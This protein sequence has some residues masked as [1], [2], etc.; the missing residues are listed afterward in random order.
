MIKLTFVL[1]ITALLQISSA[2]SFS[3]TV[4]LKFRNAKLETVLKEI[5]TQTGYDLVYI[6]PLINEAK[7]VSIN[8][9]NASLRE[10]LE[11]SFSNQSLTYT[12][13]NN[14]II[15]QQK[16]T[17]LVTS[18]LID[19]KKLSEKAPPTEVKGQVTDSKGESLIG[20]SVIV[21]GTSIGVSTDV[22]GRYTINVPDGSSVL[23]FTYIGYTTIEVS[24]SGRTSLDVTLE[25][26]TE[27]LQEVVVVGYG[28]QKKSDLTGSVVSVTAKD[29]KDQSFSNINQVLQGKVAGV[30]FTSTSGDPGENVNV[31][32]RGLNTFGGSGPLYVVDGMPMEASD[33]NSINPNDVQSTTVLKDGSAA[34]IYG[35]RSANGVILIT[36]KSGGDRPPSIS[37]NSYYGIQ[38]FNKF[39]PLLN[40]QQYADVINEAH[41]NGNFYPLQAAMN[42]P[43]NL[44]TNTD[45]QDAAIN[46]APIQDHSLTVSGGTKNA[47]YSISGGIFDQESVLAFRTYKR[48][49]SRVKTEFKIGKLTIGQSLIATKE[50]GLNLN[51]GNNLDLAYMMG[52]APTMPI[53]DPNNN[54]GYAG[55]SPAT[56]GVNNRDNILGRRDMNRAY[57]TNNKLIG[58]AYASYKIL[59]D[60]EYKLNTG[61][62]MGLRRFKNYVPQFQMNNR[63]SNARRLNTSLRESYEYL[64]EN[65]L[66]YNK[67]IKENYRISLLG[68]F[69]QQNFFGNSINGTR[70]DF[71]SN[72]IQVLSAGTGVYTVGG[73]E[74]EWALRSFLGR[75][76]ITLFDRYLITAT[77]RRDG[78]SRFGESNR[79][80]NF[81]SL[82]VG[83]NLDQE[84][85]LKDSK[86]ISGMKLRASWGRLGNQDI[87]NY[88]NQTVVSTNSRYFFGADQLAPAAVVNNLGNPFLRWETTTQ[89]NLGVDLSFLQNKIFFTADYWIKDTDGILVRTPISTVTG[90]ARGSGPFQNA[91]QLQNKGMEF[92]LGY[93]GGTGELKYGVSG[94][95]STVRNKVISL[96]AGSSIINLVENVY[97]SGTYT[98]TMPGLPM[99]HFYGH[100]ND[101]IFQTQAEINAHAT[102]AGAK[103]GDRRFRDINGDGKVDA[104][105]RT[106]IGDPWPDFDY[107]FAADASWKG[108]DVNMSFY[109]TSGKQLYDS[110]GVYLETMQGEWNNKT[111]VLNRWTGPG[112]S[113]TLPR[114]VRGDRNQNNRSQSDYVLN[115]D[116]LRLQNFQIGYTLPQSIIKRVGARN[117]RIY[118]NGQNLFTITQYPNYNADTLGGVGFNDDSGNP[119]SFGVD[120][121]STPIPSVYSFGVNL[122][123]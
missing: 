100:I 78:S 21:K 99:S 104:N 44:R 107:G 77:I 53:Y 62:N 56:V 54:S 82:A 73:N 74:D 115:A 108:F 96:G 26:N 10:V 110:Q 94:N 71:P 27:A 29:I 3:Q 17:T 101:G 112:T 50:E 34:A 86:L 113:N 84:N 87:G 121:G 22:N 2:A 43:V 51:F 91:A 36:T 8:V 1:L 106:M 16:S 66:T 40:S 123:F 37:F 15:V 122:T 58:S 118:F 12:I 75:A 30:T 47:S 111:T 35:A 42:D 80:G 25:Q 41:V 90:F 31:R 20:V 79:Y 103:P 105:D 57:T 81:P 85:F 55:P 9:I 19:I 119:L 114:A 7:P 88:S 117:A 83:W 4:S 97:Y 98:R 63:G 92:L 70:R 95:L 64:V 89:T 13:S 11:K 93:R 14:T 116:F 46:P 65:T 24:M 72:D 109:G 38:S 45:W 76:N 67:V 59:P 120:T 60:L 28:T 33:I 69:T 49:Y 6:T 18:A 48:Y 52:A 5:G 61:L 68:G 102:Q 39:I 32:I 23:V